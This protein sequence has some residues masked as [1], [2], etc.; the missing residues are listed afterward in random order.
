MEDRTPLALAETCAMCP[1][2]CRFSCPVARATASDA[3][4][5]TG[6]GTAVTRALDGTLSWEEAG[7]VA[8]ECTMCRRCNTYCDL[9]QD[10]PAYI[11][12]ARGEAV[13]RGTAPEAVFEVDRRISGTGSPYGVD[14]SDEV[15]AA[16]REAMQ[17]E[18]PGPTDV[19]YVPSC[20]A[21][22][23]EPGIVQ[24]VVSVLQGA[25]VGVRVIHPG[26]CG[27]FAA[28]LGLAETAEDLD[29]EMREA[30]DR[31]NGR[32]VVTDDP[33]CARHLG[34]VPFAV[35]A[36]ELLAD[37]RLTPR[38][39]RRAVAY[40]DPCFLGR[41]LGVYDEPRRVLERVAGT[42]IEVRHNRNDARCSGGGAGLPQ[43][44]PEAA[45]AIAAERLEEAEVAGAE[46]VVSA[47]PRCKVSLQEGELP[48][49]DLA[50]VLVVAL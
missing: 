41:H 7:P 8:Y 48:V 16:I 4:H 38:R 34:A 19:V 50:E 9:D 15:A 26:C 46:V 33:L 28:D 32:R 21:L 10:V 40:H 24:A 36:D 5:P 23:R 11:R 18:A 43:T 49:R 39:D 29:R 27:G 37:G 25:G 17:T 42:P 35:V 47:C 12:E 14:V 30:I 3:V 1:K 2:M 6:L 31:A 45:R 13:R 22:A 20:T 44:H